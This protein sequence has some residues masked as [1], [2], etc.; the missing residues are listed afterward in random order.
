MIGGMIG[1]ALHAPREALG[2]AQVSSQGPFAVGSTI[3]RDAWG[4]LTCTVI[5]K[6][7][8]ELTPGESAPLNAP[9]PL[10]RDDAH[11]DD[12]PAR[13]VRLPS[14][15]APFKRAAEVVLV[16]SA[17]APEPA[18]S[19]VARIVVGSI[20]KSVEAFPPRSLLLDGGL[21]PGT[22]LA[23]FSLR[24]EQAAGGPGTDNPAGMDVTR[25]DARGR[26]PAPRLLPPG[27]V[28]GPPGAHVP[29]C[30]LGPIAATWPTRA[31]LLAPHHRAWLLA[32]TASPLPPGFPVNFFQTAPPDQ[33]LDRALAA[34]ERLVLEGLH[35]EL[36]RLVM[37][38]TGREPWAIVAGQ[39]PQTIRLAGDLLLVDTDRGICTLTY[40]GQIQLD[41]GAEPLRVIVVGAAVAGELSAE[42]VRRIAE[43]EAE[44]VETTYVEGLSPSPG[45]P[46]AARATGAPAAP[47]SPPA[48]RP[49]GTTSPGSTHREL[50]TSGRPVLPFAREPTPSSPDGALPFRA[51][52][53]APQPS[54]QPPASE[55]FVAPAREAA[56]APPIAARVPPP[57]HVPL[58]APSFQPAE[59]PRPAAWP[60]P[61]STP[62]PPAAVTLPSLASAGLPLLSL[63]SPLDIPAPSA[64]PAPPAPRRA[65]GATSFDAAFGG[66]RATSDAAAASAREATAEAPRERP[67]RSDAGALPTSGRRQAVVSLLCFEAR[68][69]PR[70]R[71]AGRFT[72]A[73]ASRPRPRRAQGVDQPAK[74]DPPDDRSDVL[75]LLSCGQPADAAE[76]HRALVDSLDDLDDLDPPLVLVAG[77]LRP[78]F[79][80][81]EMLRAIIAVVQQVAGGDKKILSSIAVGQAALAAPVVPRPET[82]LGLVKQIDLSAA[83][84]SLPAGYVLAEVERV[85]VEGRKY[86]RRTLLGAARVRADLTL[87]RSGE[88]MPLYLP[89]S[90]A[91]S[92]PLLP[93]FPVVALCEIIPR[94]DLTEAQ[95]E[96]LLAAA[97]GRVLHSR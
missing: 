60:G 39:A 64:V 34:N 22:R 81:I 29:S 69:V 89:D 97:L 35:P 96:A 85:L 57:A 66:V 91:A 12:D 61:L 3:W 23:R 82:T 2:P 14:D 52:E 65:S 26:V 27:H 50:S 10:Q 94:E 36:K 67:A 71:S 18:S 53:A 8:Y 25:A 48:L 44:D 38:L 45:A 41:D 31:S 28:L 70:I 59:I 7:T 9:H 79:D 47:G 16:G 19:L 83:S 4:R 37:S 5:A 93:A 24:Y 15:L 86:K 88:A 49:P 6:A 33:W 42:Y 74:E 77:E 76:I 32:P 84:L 54:A 56:P 92:L 17:F 63:G 55:L 78:T 30:G 90:A 58:P 13:S 11:W 95:D 51:A 1:G 80:E 87:A 20:D 43:P 46:F 75:R 73:L 40:R 68:I 62:L 72:A 21:E